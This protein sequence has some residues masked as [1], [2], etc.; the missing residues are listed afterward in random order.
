MA[1]GNG[2]ESSAGIARIALILAA[3]A[4]AMAVLGLFLPVQ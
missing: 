1:D 3:M 4:F 2:S